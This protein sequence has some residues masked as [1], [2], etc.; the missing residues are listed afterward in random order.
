MK[1]PI[2]I[3]AVISIKKLL[4]IIGSTKHTAIFD[5]KLVSLLQLVS[6]EDADETLQMIDVVHGS[7]DEF[8]GRD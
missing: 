7:H 8:V 5:H 3:P 1:W 6:A 4:F 2:P